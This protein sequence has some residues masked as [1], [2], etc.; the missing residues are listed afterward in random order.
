M[1]SGTTATVPPLGLWLDADVLID[2]TQGRPAAVA[3]F[4]TLPD[5]PAVASF[6]AM[7]L[8]A[9]CL[10]GRELKQLQ[11]FLRPF[12]LLWPTETD[13]Q[14]ALSEYLPLRL[15]H[16]IGLLD[17]VIAATAT[18]AG[19]TLATLNVRHFRH[20]PGLTFQ[21]PYIK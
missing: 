16:G 20:I 4:A 9:G 8:I 6:A 1:T 5:L 13:L 2:L 21:R 7:E 14:R 19:L 17:T 18:G 10:N 15:A 3:W 11:R 12:P